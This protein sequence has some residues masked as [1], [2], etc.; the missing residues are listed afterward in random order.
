[1]P[2]VSVSA[3]GL[4]LGERDG[5]LPLDLG[6]ALD[7]AALR[8]LVVAFLATVLAA[9]ALAGLVVF[10]ALAFMA[11]AFLAL[12][13]LALAFLVPVF[14]SAPPFLAPVAAAAGGEAVD[15]LPR[16]LAI[17]FRVRGVS[18]LPLPRAD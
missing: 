15:C 16:L 7:L 2:S 18:T 4:A 8:G 9:R 3:E 12:A 11:L 5:C 17:F 6:G 10:L 1:G 13:F 14:F